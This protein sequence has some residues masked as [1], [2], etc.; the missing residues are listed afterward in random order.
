MPSKYA[1]YDQ[2]GIEYNRTRKADPYLAK[3][4]LAHLGQRTGAHY[5]DLGCGT[6][7][8]T[9]ALHRQGLAFTGVDPSEEMLSKARARCGSINWL[10]GTAEA[11]PLPD[12]SMDGM[13]ATLT[14]HHWSSL[15]QGFAEVARVLKP[16]SRIAIFTT[17]PQQTIAYWLM[18]YFPNMMQDSIKVLPQLDAIQSAMEAS[19]IVLT[20]TEK[21]FVQDDLQDLFLYSGKF[22]PELYFDPQVRSGISSFSALSNAEEVEQGLAKLRSDIDNGHVYDVMEEYENTLGDY[23]FVS[24]VRV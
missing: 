2:I 10:N 4:M 24:A 11:I 21:Y 17:T 9:I 19:G 22:N 13:L 3:R 6:G 5:L 15:E 12:A 23:L 20:E 18:H 16:G 8:Y 1:T 14:L 7:N